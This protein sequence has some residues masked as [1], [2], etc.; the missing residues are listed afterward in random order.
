[1]STACIGEH[2]TG[3]NGGRQAHHTWYHPISSVSTLTARNRVS[4]ARWKLSA[5][6]LSATAAQ[7]SGRH[8][9]ARTF[10]MISN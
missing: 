5:A 9:H 10:F 2:V 7:V 3:K 1:M 8:S 6:A 4:I